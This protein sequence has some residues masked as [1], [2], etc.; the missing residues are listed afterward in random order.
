MRTTLL[1]M[2]A[3][4]SLG[5]AAAAAENPRV[6]PPGPPEYQQGYVQ[7]CMSGFSDADRDGYQHLYAKD[8]TRYENDSLYRAGWDEAHAKCYE[9][10][11]RNPRLVPGGG[12]NL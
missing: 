7:G 5:Y 6:P 12:S 1:A 11:L 3:I 2:T 9:E 4:A 10:E 8:N